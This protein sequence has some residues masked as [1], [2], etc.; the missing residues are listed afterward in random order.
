M[1]YFEIQSTSRA[2]ATIYINE[3]E[4]GETPVFVRTEAAPTGGTKEDLVIKAVWNGGG[5]NDTEFRIP[6]GSNPQP[7]V[8][9]GQNGEREY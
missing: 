2:V 6:A 3:E 4:R 7:I 8:K 9:V 1:I 5:G